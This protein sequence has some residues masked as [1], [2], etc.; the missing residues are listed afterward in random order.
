[1]TPTIISNITS[2]KE[3][4]YAFRFSVV[5]IDKLNNKDEFIFIC[6]SLSQCVTQC[7]GLI[8]YM[9]RHKGMSLLYIFPNDSTA[10]F[11]TT[12]AKKDGFTGV[13]GMLKCQEGVP[14][15]LEDVRSTYIEL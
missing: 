4:P 6:N 10:T 9:F 3:R 1:M 7:T 8:N 12:Y 14:L 2:L 15:T 11:R 5:F 13:Y